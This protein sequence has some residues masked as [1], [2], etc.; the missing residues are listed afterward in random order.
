M[1]ELGIET[2]TPVTLARSS[3]TE[4][5]FLQFPLERGFKNYG[6]KIVTPPPSS[7]NFIGIILNILQY[8]SSELQIDLPNLKAAYLIKK[9]STDQIICGH[10]CHELRRVL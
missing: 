3:T 2:G 7:L 10:I 4:L 5:S 6:S 1:A 9:I 8:T